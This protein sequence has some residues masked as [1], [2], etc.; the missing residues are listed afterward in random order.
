MEEKKNWT[1]VLLLCLSLGFM[2]CAS[3]PPPVRQET[4]QSVEV[5]DDSTQL[6]L[7]KHT[8]QREYNPSGHEKN[9]NSVYI[10]YDNRV[11]IL[12]KLYRIIAELRGIIESKEVSKENRNSIAKS[13]VSLSKQATDIPFE[14][15]R[16]YC[17]IKFIKGGKP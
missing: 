4:L 15:Q 7:C 8:A 17:P 6:R 11:A 5:E 14:K 1:V 2:S 10:R 13:L 16:D 9:R 3:T 12:S